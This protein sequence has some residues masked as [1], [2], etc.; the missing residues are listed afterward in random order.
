MKRLD[1]LLP[2]VGVIGLIAIWYVAVWYQIV[3]KVLLPQ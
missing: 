3:D 1:P 2:I